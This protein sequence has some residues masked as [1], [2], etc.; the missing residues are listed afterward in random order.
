MRII[1]FVIVG[2]PLLV[3]LATPSIAMSSEDI[4]DMWLPA[5]HLSSDGPDPECI[6]V[7]VNL[8][9]GGE[10]GRVLQVHYP[11]SSL[12]P[13]DRENRDL[14]KIY[15]LVSAL[16]VAVGAKEVDILRWHATDAVTCRYRI[17]GNKHNRTCFTDVPTQPLH[18]Y[19][20][21]RCKR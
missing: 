4:T 11:G 10:I 7:E 21:Y 17:D 18:E 5:L 15:S 20:A 8:I 19:R 2:S 1:H 12:F 9:A 14:D 16:V 6:D 13:I 3:S